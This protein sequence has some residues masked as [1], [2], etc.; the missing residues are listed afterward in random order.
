MKNIFRITSLFVFLLALAAC[1]P[2]TS[3][4]TQQA[5]ET[6]TNFFV[7][8]HDG[9]YAEA[10]ALYGG[11]Y[12]GL[13]AMNPDIDPNDHAALWENGCT[14]NGYMCLTSK[15]VI[16]ATQAGDTF[17][18]VVE[19]ANADG[20]LFVLGP[21]CGATET[22]MPPVSQFEYTVTKVGEKFFVQ[23]LPPYVP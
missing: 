10:D 4:E 16:S 13:T 3:N 11:S 12:D 20:S 5:Q 6:L 23:G 21:C 1:A 17:H 22:E 7:L 18:F 19:F 14:L 8:L 15:N 9:K 2:G